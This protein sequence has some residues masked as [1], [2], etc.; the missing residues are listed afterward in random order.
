MTATVNTMAALL[1]A[2]APEY[3][4]GLISIAGGSFPEFGGLQAKTISGTKLSVRCRTNRPKGGFRAIGGAVSGGVELSNIELKEYA[5]KIFD[6]SFDLETAYVNQYAD[7][8]D[9]CLAEEMAAHIEGTTEALCDTLWNGGNGDSFPALST[10]IAE[11]NIVDAKGDAAGA[12]TSVYLVCD[13]GPDGFSWVLGRNGKVEGSEPYKTKAANGN[14]AYRTDLE[15]YVGWQLP[16]AR[17][18]VRICNVDPV[19]S[20][21]GIS[22]D[23]IGQA[24]AKLP[25]GAKAKIVMHPVIREQLRKSRTA[26]NATGAPAA[27]PVESL[28]MPIMV[29]DAIS[30]TETVVA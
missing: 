22:D 12:V 20:A 18:A 16:N 13:E 4:K 10:L 15:A 1:I 7:G 5:L 27:L 25:T 30:L 8:I 6:A 28:G 9:A 14:S 26:T 11:G 19:D 23:L 24:M 17:K 29:S 2:N 3:T 21:T